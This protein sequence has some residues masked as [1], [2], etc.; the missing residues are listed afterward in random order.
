[1]RL[2][3]LARHQWTST[4]YE[5]MLAAGVFE[6]IELLCGDVVITGAAVRPYRWTL[7]D[8]EQLIALGLLEGKHVELMQGEILTMASMGELNALTIMQLNYALLPHFNP[9]TGF[10]FRIQ[11]PLALPAL[12]SEPEPDIA[13]VA[14]DAP[15]NEAGRPTSA[16][17]LIEVAES[18]LAYDRERKG[19]LYAAAGIQEYWLVNLP[20]RCLEVYRQ[21]LPDASSFSGWRYQARQRLQEGDHVAPLAAPEV[22]VAVD[23]LLPRR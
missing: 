6:K 5:R 16:S 13:I 19:L 18:S 17:L 21:P 12:I 1:M 8:Y 22:V 2:A 14:L 23:A 4:D 20:E 9:G 3:T 11:M 10:H 7:D 15:T